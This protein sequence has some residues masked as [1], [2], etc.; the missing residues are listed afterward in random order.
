QEQVTAGREQLEQQRRQ[1]DEGKAQLQQMLNRKATLDALQKAA[2]GQGSEAV[3]HWLESH[4]LARKPRLAE[5][6]QVESGWERAVETV[7]GDYLQ[8]VMIDQLD[9]AQHWLGSFKEGHLSLWQQGQGAAAVNTGAAGTLAAKVQS[10][11][12]VSGLLA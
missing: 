7:L 10:R 6:L 2:L 3:S 9:P 4:Q 11:Q 8:A 1:L 12:D 5:Q